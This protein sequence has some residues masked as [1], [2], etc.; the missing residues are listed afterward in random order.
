MDI[1]PKLKG[2]LFV[3]IK[4]GHDGVNVAMSIAV[5]TD[6]DRVFIESIDCQSVRN[7][8][9]W[10]L[11]F[12]MNTN[13]QSIVIDGA[14]GQSILT[15]EMAS[16]KIKKPILPTVKEVI[17]ANALFEQGIFAKNICHTGQ[18]SLNNVV[19]NCEKRAIG[20]N[21]G[22]G[23]KNI[24][25]GAEGALLDSIIYAY[26]VCLTFKKAQKQRANY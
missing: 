7:G 17:E 11:N 5:K 2:K 14:N 20:T 9:H 26:W 13:I 22:F 10:I 25:E 21:G 23:Y 3:G 1:L 15:K 18:P 12:L 19:T 16:Y 8:N 4:Y 24:K 6:E